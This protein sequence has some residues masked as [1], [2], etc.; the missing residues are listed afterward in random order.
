ML[1]TYFPFASMLQRKLL[2]DPIF[3]NETRLAQR[4]RA[5]YACSKFLSLILVLNNLVQIFQEIF[6]QEFRR[7]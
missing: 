3:R 2:S 7:I 1:L 4:L 5:R 6:K